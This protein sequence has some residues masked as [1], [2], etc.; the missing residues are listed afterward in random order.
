MT[1]VDLDTVAAV[2][3]HA[4]LT[5]LP[6]EQLRQLYA[7]TLPLDRMVL[8]EDDDSRRCEGLG[9]VVGVAGSYPLRLHV[10]GGPGAVIDAAG[11]SWVSVLPTARRRGVLRAMMTRLLADRRDAGEAVAALWASEPAI[12]GRF[13]Y[14]LATHHLAAKLPR[15]PGLLHA[16]DSDHLVVRYVSATPALLVDV[17]RRAAAADA[18]AGTPV[19]DE[20]WARLR[21]ADL[22]E[23]RG[24][25]SELHAV[26][27]L[28]P[29]R[30]DDDAVRG[31]ALFSDKEEWPDG[32]AA[33]VVGLRE[34][35][36]VD[37]AARAALWRFLLDR[38]LSSGVDVGILD[39]DDPVLRWLPNLRA[40]QAR[41]RD[42]LYVRLVD[43]PRALVA[44]TASAPL[45]VVVRVTDATCPWNDGVWH[46]Q[47]REAAAPFVV[48]KVGVEKVE[49]V[50]GEAD[51]DLTVDVRELGSA[52]LGGV[53]VASSARAGLVQA[54]RAGAV[55][56]LSRALATDRVPFFPFLF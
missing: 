44:R 38:D 24:G 5:P 45:D 53:T 23:R 11:V 15:T 22:A 33:G 1:A 42:A 4:F 2:D 35:T 10:P 20:R 43:L 36:A 3:A 49:K 8:A 48:E 46:L 50:G 14:G 40:A 55:D 16:P 30:G 27:A 31:Y 18:R 13:G 56:E 6:G 9:G 41:L 28:D 47:A 25:A 7:E 32:I 12:Y 37:V 34:L 54:Q 17:A 52:Y 26:V 51:V 21:L 39:P 29:R 19:Y